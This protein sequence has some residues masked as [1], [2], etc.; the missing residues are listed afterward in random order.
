MEYYTMV[1]CMHG[2]LDVAQK[3]PD[4]REYLPGDSM[5]IKPQS[6]QMNL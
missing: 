3:K 6:R 1:R 5:D 2:S 4:T